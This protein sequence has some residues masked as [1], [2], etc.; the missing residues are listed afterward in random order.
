[1]KNFG[2]VFFYRLLPPIVGAIAA[3]R[4]PKSS[5]G[6]IVFFYNWWWWD[7]KR[8]TLIQN[9]DFKCFKAYSSFN[10]LKVFFYFYLIEFC[11]INIV[12]LLH[13]NLWLWFGSLLFH[14]QLSRSFGGDVAAIWIKLSI[15]IFGDTFC[16]YLL[17]IG[18]R[19]HFCFMLNFR[20]IFLIYIFSRIF[21]RLAA[22][23]VILVSTVRS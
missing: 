3:K 10:H 5:L 2:V 15:F 8:S 9:L 6:R 17:D 22:C 19:F 11:L 18:G 23:V 13:L 7:T 14:A 16:T 21:A 1:M 4:K 12:Y 20:I